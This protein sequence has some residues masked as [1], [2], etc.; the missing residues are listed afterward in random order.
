[1]IKTGYVIWSSLLL[2]IL[3][4]ENNAQDLGHILNEAKQLEAGFKDKE[5]L[6]KYL[7]VLRYQPTHITAL[8]KASELYSILGKRQTGKENQKKYYNSAKEYAQKALQSNPNSAEANFVMA[9]ALGRIAMI[10]SGD[11]KIKAIN[12]V[13]S[14]AEKSIRFDPS[15]YKGYFVLGKWHYEVSDLSSIEKWLVKLA[16]GELPDASLDVAIRNFEKSKQL[17]PG[18]LLAYLELAKSYHRKDNDAKAIE[19]LKTLL[20]LPNLHSDDATIKKQAQKLL[21]QYK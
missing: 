5:A 9:V 8:C 21:Q 17:N 4:F 7:E 19:Y 14:Y 11:E 12:D 20:K 2:S 6:D 10:S 15:S 3:P 13:K 18:F 16:Y 1:M